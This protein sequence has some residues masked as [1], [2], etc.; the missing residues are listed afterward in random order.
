M[1]ACPN[2]IIQFALRS[3]W[4]LSRYEVERG[5]GRWR[6]KEGREMERQEMVKEPKM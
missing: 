5:G 3:K 2:K 4:R 1:A 6:V